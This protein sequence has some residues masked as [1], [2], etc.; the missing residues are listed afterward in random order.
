MQPD[1]ALRRLPVRENDATLRSGSM[2]RMRMAAV[3]ASVLAVGLG[4]ATQAEPSPPPPAPPA[5]SSAIQ[6]L[7]G[8]AADSG[9]DIAMRDGTRTLPYVAP[10]PESPA[11][12]AP[13]FVAPEPA[14]RGTPWFR[15]PQ[16]AMRYL[17]AAYSRHDDKAL[18]QVTTPD[19]RSA[20]LAMRGYAPTL[21]LKSCT[22]LPAGDYDCT[23]G[24]SVAKTGKRDG[25]ALFR[26][27]PAIRHGWYM[28]VLEDCGDGSEG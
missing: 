14:K 16:A 11:W 12:T 23:F 9:A 22:R 27:G 1:R 17:A 19:A 8:S 2:G 7:T 28:T 10:A 26:V 6:L 4:L 13:P 5:R 18:A 25:Y 3:T 20:L 24:H 21:W 15:T